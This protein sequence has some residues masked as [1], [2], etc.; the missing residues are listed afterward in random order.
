MACRLF[1][2]KPLPANVDL[3]L[4]GP[5]RTNLRKNMIGIQIFLFKKIHLKMSSAKWLPFCVDLNVLT[6]FSKPIEQLGV[7][8]TTPTIHAI[9]YLI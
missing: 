2:A 7:L 6:Q 9:I 3:L 8:S 5:L 1:S 4:I